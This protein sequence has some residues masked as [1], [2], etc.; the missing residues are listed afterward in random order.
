MKFTTTNGSEQIIVGKN[1]AFSGTTIA[2][3]GTVTTADINGGNIDGTIIGAAS[4]AAGT[5]NCRYRTK[6]W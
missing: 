6:C 2:D 3:L 4:P 5:C 1:S